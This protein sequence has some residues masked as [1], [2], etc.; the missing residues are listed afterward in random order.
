MWAVVVAGIV[1]SKFLLR[2]SRLRRLAW[3]L[4]ARKSS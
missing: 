4:G 1:A 3:E 2:W